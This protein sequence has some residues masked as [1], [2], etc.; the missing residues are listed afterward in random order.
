MAATWEDAAVATA[1]EGVRSKTELQIARR[2]SRRALIPENLPRAARSS[3]QPLRAQRGD[4]GRLFRHPRP[5]RATPAVIMRRRSGHGL[6]TACG[7][8]IKARPLE[9][10]PGGERP[11]EDPRPL[12]A[13]VRADTQTRCS[14]SPRR[15]PSSTSGPATPDHLPT[16]ATPPPTSCHRATRGGASSSPAPPRADAGPMPS[17]SPAASRGDVLV[18]ALGKA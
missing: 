4:R 13:A 5:G 8:Y 1:P 16:S 11:G 18:E 10:C 15:F 7:S 9:S 12:D 2:A 14:S 6:S 3:R 17:A